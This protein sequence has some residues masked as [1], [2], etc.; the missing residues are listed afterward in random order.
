[1][2]VGRFAYRAGDFRRAYDLLEDTARK[3]PNNPDALFDLALASYSVGRV[4]EAE[5]GAQAALTAKG[6]FP[7]AEEAKRFL[8]LAK[9][10][11]DFSQPLPADNA[12]EELILPEPTSLPALMLT[13]RVREQSGQYSQA[14]QIYEDQI[15]K[16][17]PEFAPAWRRLAWLYAEHLNDQAKALDAGIKARRIFADDAALSRLLGKAAFHCKDYTKTVQFLSGSTADEQRDGNLLFYLGMAY[18]QLSRKDE[19]KSA[20]HKALELHLDSGL[21]QEANRV[22]ASLK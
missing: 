10:A 1:V 21:A 15:L 14:R 4:P 8:E 18:Y 17:A 3:L 6:P 2:E 5:Q 12:I 9:L 13:A 16:L 7:R 11:D 19:S 20:L 22:L